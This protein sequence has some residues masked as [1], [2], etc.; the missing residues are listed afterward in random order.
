MPVLILVHG[1]FRNIT[2]LSPFRRLAIA[3]NIQNLP[4]RS[5]NIVT[6][7]AYHGIDGY[8]EI[9]SQVTTSCISTISREQTAFTIPAQS[10][11]IVDV[12]QPEL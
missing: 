1:Q 2:D 11:N 4:A 8:Q 12:R 3:R 6:W 9:P 10:G 7:Q 5:L